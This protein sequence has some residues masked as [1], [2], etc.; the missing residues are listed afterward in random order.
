MLRAHVMEIEEREEYIY[1]CADAKGSTLWARVTEDREC[2]FLTNVRRH[3]PLV[4]KMY[5]RLGETTSWSRV[6]SI[7][8][9]HAGFEI[10]SQYSDRTACITLKLGPQGESLITRNGT[11]AATTKMHSLPRDFVVVWAGTLDTATNN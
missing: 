2:Q 7:K 1:L 10:D 4:A 8:R 11:L 3:Y 5:S 9:L 6:V